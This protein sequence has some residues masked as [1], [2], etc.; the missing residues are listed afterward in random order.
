MDAGVHQLQGA[1]EPL[2]RRH[3]GIY[4]VVVALGSNQGHRESHL[5]HAVARLGEF[6]D[7]LQVSTFVETK[8]VGVRSQPDFLNGVVTG[9]SDAQPQTLLD[10]LRAIEAER[11]RTR[12]FDGSA[13]TLDLDLIL[14]GDEVV[15]SPEL[16][17]PHPR[18]RERRFVLEPLCEI[19]PETRDPVT[20]FSA[21]EL[22]QRL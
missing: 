11:E 13:R 19:A 2:K 16:T 4:R 3:R 6:L 14:V 1:T 10:S 15:E 17:L 18:F 5:Q 21:R 22:L 8:P 20:M 9:L 12:P 7:Q